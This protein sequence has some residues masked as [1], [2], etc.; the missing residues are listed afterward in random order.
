MDIIEISEDGT[1]EI[2]QKYALSE[3]KRKLTIKSAWVLKFQ[4]YP[5]GSIQVTER[6]YMRHPPMN[7]YIPEGFVELDG[8][9]FEIKKVQSQSEE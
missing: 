7:P 4:T 6:M 9:R 1:C 2:P 5:K 3:T 8:D